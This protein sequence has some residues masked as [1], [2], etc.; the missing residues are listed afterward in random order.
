MRPPS[1]QVSY[2]IGHG[3]TVDWCTYNMLNSQ[4]LCMELKFSAQPRAAVGERDG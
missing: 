1:V 4:E 3:G 2:L